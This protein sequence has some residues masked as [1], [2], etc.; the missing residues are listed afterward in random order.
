MTRI[1]STIAL[2]LVCMDPLSAQIVP[3]GTIRGRVVDDSTNLPV[4][5]ANAYVANTVLGSS[6]DSTGHFVIEHVPVG[7]HTLIVSFI[8]YRTALT[9]LDLSESGNS[10]LV[11]RLRPKELQA[12]A[13]EIKA[14]VPGDWR[15]NLATFER[16]FLGTSENARLCKIINPEIL[17][18]TSGGEWIE[19][20][21]TPPQQ[22][23]RIENRA[24]GY[25]VYYI[26]TRFRYV[27]KHLETGGVARFEPLTPRDA[28]EAS[29]WQKNRVKAY[30]GSLRH[31]LSSLVSG[32]TGR[33]GF[34]VT[35]VTQVLGR[36]RDDVDLRAIVHP[37]ASPFKKT[38]SFNDYLEV[39]YTRADAEEAYSNYEWKVGPSMPSGHEPQTSWIALE[40][41][42]VTIDADGNIDGP[43]VI[44][45]TGYWTFL[46]VADLLPMDYHP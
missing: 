7:P 15:K 32:T 27:Q 36:Y 43:F 10:P 42:D 16:W 23:V 2:L 3:Q 1:L 11:V 19:F 24:L 28:D 22:P 46:R 20:E 6:T 21:A 4:F 37:T 40:A 45:E 38:L 31:F 41:P 29:R 14:T 9:E 12:A 5:L 39:T 17:D 33:E 18:F 26:L 13:V 34:E 44:Q 35:H 25:T 8:G 30:E